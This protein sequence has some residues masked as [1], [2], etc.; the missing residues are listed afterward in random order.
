MNILLLTCANE[1]E[2]DKI[3]HALLEKHL[4]VCIKKMPV[5]SSF[6]W[7]GKIGSA[8]EVLLLM[9]SIESKF[10]KIENEVRKLHSYEAFVLVSLPVTK[11]SAGVANW[12]KENL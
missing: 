9:E 3:T 6:L 4:V 11:M 12:I 1:K 8:K 2:A 10:D 7:K 5:S